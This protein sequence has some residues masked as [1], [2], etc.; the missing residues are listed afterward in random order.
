MGV[1]VWVYVCTGVRTHTHF[2]ISIADEHLG[3]FHLLDIVNNIINN[4]L[5]SS[6]QFLNKVFFDPL[7]TMLTDTPFSVINELRLFSPKTVQRGI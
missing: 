6:E 3:C 4:G 1:C 7:T 5:L 2:I